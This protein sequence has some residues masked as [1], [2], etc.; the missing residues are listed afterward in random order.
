MPPSIITRGL[1]YAAIAYPLYYLCDMQMGISKIIRIKSACKEL[2]NTV[3]SGTSMFIRSPGG[4]SCDE[5]P[6]GDKRI[7]NRERTH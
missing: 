2:R 1:R 4:I 5:L 7:P 3:M 6:Q